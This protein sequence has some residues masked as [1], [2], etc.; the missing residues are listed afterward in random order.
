[1]TANKNPAVVTKSTSRYE[2]WQN[3]IDGAI[4]DSQWAEYDCGIQR[5]V[6]QCNRHLSNTSG[7][8]PVDWRLIKAMVWT[9]SGGPDGRAWHNNPMQIGNP[10]DPGLRA[11]LS[12]KEGGDLIIPPDLKKKRTIA[13]AGSSP[14]MNI[15]AGTAYLL[16]R[17]A[18]YGE[19][20]VAD[21][22]DKSLHEVVVRMGDSLDGLARVNGTTGDILKRLN[23]GTGPLR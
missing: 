22:D 10:G 11:L 21:K 13:S 5:S 19:A 1:M 4:T 16:M 12:D 2:L 20:T 14:Q 3:T 6:I 7:F 23:A 15:H 17:L 18:K 9:E 8:C